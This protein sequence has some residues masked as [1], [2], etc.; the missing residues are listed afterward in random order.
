MQIGH[1]ADR[2]HVSASM[3]MHCLCQNAQHSCFSLAK[4]QIM[5]F[6]SAVI[7]MKSTLSLIQCIRKIAIATSVFA[8]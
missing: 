3:P 6:L 5:L 2:P 7:L 1:M 8:A 4:R